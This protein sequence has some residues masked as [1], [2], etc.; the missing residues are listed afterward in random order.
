MRSRRES[1]NPQSPTLSETYQNCSGL[2]PGT[3]ASLRQFS[4]GGPLGRHVL[5]HWGHGFPTRSQ[6]GRLSIAFEQPASYSLRR[7][8]G[9]PQAAIL[10]LQ[11]LN[12]GIVA[13]KAGYNSSSCIWCL[14]T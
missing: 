13:L 10:G 4:H 3:S 6:R 1:L 7:A 14:V 12:N 8:L 11:V 9:G 2:G 5:W